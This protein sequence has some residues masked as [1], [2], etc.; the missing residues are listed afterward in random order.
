MKLQRKPLLSALEYCR[1]VKDRQSL[2]ILSCVKMSAMG[3]WLIVEAVGP[4]AVAR[5]TV[6]C[7]GD[8]KPF[9]VDMDRLNAIVGCMSCDSIEIKVEMQR[10]IIEGDS[11]VVLNTLPAEEFATMPTDEAKLIDVYAKD[12]AELIQAVAFCEGDDPT[13]PCLYDLMFRIKGGFMDAV[14]ANGRMVA[15]ARQKTEY[16][17]DEKII[18]FPAKYTSTLA[19]VLLEQGALLLE[20]D[21]YIIARS[22]NATCWVKKSLHEFPAAWEQIMKSG[23]G[24]KSID[25]PTSIIEQACQNAV[26]LGRIEDASQVIIHWGKESLSVSVPGQHGDWKRSDV[27]DIEGPSTDCCLNVEYIGKAV[28]KFQDRVQFTPTEFMSYFSGGD[29]KVAIGHMRRLK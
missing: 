29:L 7:L 6:E 13:R 10:I 8:A 2:P 14:C 22:V 18:S 11:R 17:G 20:S 23:D 12:V 19:P 4:V 15:N 1:K 28:R 25:I 24:H 21:N 9:C 26:A 27:V 16:A 3:E 5:R